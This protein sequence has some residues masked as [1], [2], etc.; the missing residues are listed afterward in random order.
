MIQELWRTV[1]L[2]PLGVCLPFRFFWKVK[3]ISQD[4]DFLRAR[5]KR[6]KMAPSTTVE[7][8]QSREHDCGEKDKGVQLA[9]RHVLWEGNEWTHE[10]LWL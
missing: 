5:R 3:K 1:I 10:N 9:Q 8:Y 4:R 6:E 7:V 2:P